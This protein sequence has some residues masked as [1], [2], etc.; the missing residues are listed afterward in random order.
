MNTENKQRIFKTNS[1]EYDLDEI[2]DKMNSREEDYLNWRTER[3][4]KFDADTARQGISQVRT[5]LASGD[6][7]I[8]SGGGFVSA[9]GTQFNPVALD[10]LHRAIGAVKPI[11]EKEKEAFGDKHSLKTKFKNRFYGGNDP[12]DLSMWTDKAKSSQDLVDMLTEYKTDVDT[13]DV[14]YDGSPWKDKTRHMEA[15]DRL[16]NNLNNGTIDAS[17]SADWTALGGDKQF[18][19]KIMGLT[20]PEKSALQKEWEEQEKML[21][22]AGETEENIQSRKKQFFEMK[23][24]E[25]NAGYYNRDYLSRFNNYVGNH[26]LGGEDKDLL[27]LNVLS[28]QIDSSNWTGHKNN[29]GDQVEPWLRR[30]DNSTYADN[31]YKEALKGRFNPELVKDGYNNNEILY[32]YM[33]DQLRLDP[34]QF[35]P[36]DNNENEVY[37]KSTINHEDGTAVKYNTSTNKFTKVHLSQSRYQDLP[38]LL[39]EMS[40]RYRKY[41]ESYSPLVNGG[42]GI[43]AY[44]IPGAKKGGKLNQIKALR[45][46]NKIQYALSGAELARMYEQERLNKYD[47]SVD[48]RAEQQGKTREQI[49]AGDA[50]AKTDTK[51]NTI[52]RNISTGFDVAGAAASF[53]PVI[54]NAAGAILGTIGTVGNLA[55]DAFDDSVSREEMMTNLAINAGLTG[56][57]LVP[58]GGTASLV[59][60]GLKTAKTAVQVGMP[61]YAGYNVL[62]NWDRIKELRKKADEGKL[63]HAERR[64]LNGYYSMASGTVTGVKGNAA[65]AAKHL[66]NNWAGKTAAA[67]ADPFTAI[68]AAKG[69]AKA[70]AVF[71][72]MTRDTKSIK[73]NAKGTPKGKQ[74]TFTDSEGNEFVINKK[75]RTAML[76]AE[77]QAKAAGKT[78]AE[79]DQ[80]IGKAW[81][82]N[83][84]VATSY[85]RE[86]STPR[87]WEADVNNK[88]VQ[89]ALTAP[90]DPSGNIKIGNIE[91]S[92]ES[93][94]I[95]KDTYKNTIDSLK[96]A[97][98]RLQGVS[99]DKLD[100]AKHA[101]GLEAAKQKFAD[102]AEAKEVRIDIDPNAPK[103]GMSDAGTLT[104]GANK[105]HMG[106]SQ[107]NFDDNGTSAIGRYFSSGEGNRFDVHS[108]IGRRNLEL[109]AMQRQ[110]AQAYLNDV[111]GE[112]IGNWAMKHMNTNWEMA[113]NMSGFRSNT[114]DRLDRIAIGKRD[115]KRFLA[116]DAG[117]QQA[118]LREYR[119]FTEEGA[120]VAAKVNRQ[121]GGKATDAQIDDAIKR[122]LNHNSGKVKQAY[123]LAKANGY[124]GT[125][126]DYKASIMQQVRQNYS[127]G[128]STKYH[129]I[130]L[131][132]GDQQLAQF[133]SQFDD[134]AYVTGEARARGL[135]G[136]DVEI[137]RQLA[138]P[139]NKALLDQLK[140]LD[141]DNLAKKQ[142]A[143]QLRNAKRQRVA[144]RNAKFSE[145]SNTPEGKMYI[146]EFKL[147]NGGRKPN[148]SNYAKDRL[149]GKLESYLNSGKTRAELNEFAK[150]PEGARILNGLTT[151]QDKINA[152]KAY[153]QQ[154]SDAVRTRQQDADIATFEALDNNF[155]ITS[156]QVRDANF[157][158]VLNTEINRI[159]TENPSLG[160]QGVTADK[161]KAYFESK[162]TH[163]TTDTFT[164]LRTKLLDSDIDVLMEIL[165]PN[166]SRLGRPVTPTTSVTPT[167]SAV[168]PGSLHS[169]PTPMFGRS[170][171]KL[172]QL[173]DLR[174][175]FTTDTTNKFAQG[176]IIKAQ[177]GASAEQFGDSGGRS[178]GSGFDRQKWEQMQYYGTKA[179]SEALRYYNYIDNQRNNQRILD[180]DKSMKVAV[181]SPNNNTQYTPVTGNFNE[182]QEGVKNTG[183]ILSQMDRMAS[184][185]NNVE[186]GQAGMLEGQLKAQAQETEHNRVDDA[187][188][189]QSMATN[190]A[191]AREVDAQNRAIADKNMGKFVAQ[192]TYVK[193]Q[194]KAMLSN[195][196]TNENTRMVKDIINPLDTANLALKERAKTKA[197]A[198]FKQWTKD[199]ITDTDELRRLYE[200]YENATEEDA[201]DK[202]WE[203]YAAEKKRLWNQW[204]DQYN[205][206]Y[207]RLLSGDYWQN[208]KYGKNFK[209][210]KGGKVDDSRVKRRAEDLKELRKDI[211]HSITTNRKALDNLS[212]ATLLTLKKMLDV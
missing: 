162:L 66:G 49:L 187:A 78:G 149:N 22:E 61:I 39:R 76:A 191:L 165:H 69:N 15:I 54:G 72:D 140:Q 97:D 107:L 197:Y 109:R 132:R 193:N 73:I 104:Q 37:I 67:I 146:E 71:K 50:A 128:A 203:A 163:G 194:T 6:I 155:K 178:N 168:P 175:N 34:E 133:T 148:A 170:G 90:Q 9:S 118:A 115:H 94:K 161:L 68:G 70:S 126:D 18:F 27:S 29:E 159:L 10:L 19:D 45:N 171:G 211:R 147:A 142:Q 153:K 188:V 123:N 63:S 144:E 141:A 110:R 183:Q 179:A 64:E 52:L 44:L 130:A 48:K 122:N 174:Q 134:L 205:D 184:L 154:Y 7:S 74:W 101:I 182:R 53:I 32:L 198:Q 156:G 173:K 169:T 75:Q 12:E 177:N 1:S 3:D 26:W 35:I 43:S 189:K 180:I 143:E 46:G 77:R 16:I 190:T 166:S 84:D 25:L 100:A 65:K 125:L 204:E 160:R 60:K 112:G 181:E 201:K 42:S 192:D 114:D 21:R 98:T 56:L 58:G 30:G 105:W 102:L 62:N 11:P 51:G 40:A 129:D 120:K 199:N 8:G 202:A 106:S 207:D 20:P 124:T 14:N 138:D 81:A 23:L 24:A 121:N 82:E 117:K 158:A 151:E 79:I 57:M 136:T 111:V 113:Q 127:E 150:T 36:I 139:K 33:Q 47:Q 85:S 200:V 86:I 5:A 185:T 89:D 91:F 196:Q 95:L 83:A 103:F 208:W 4:S 31:L 88:A 108:P 116:S 186:A 80:A 210:K 96:P 137:Q 135:S 38:T 13:W 152:M 164:D 99:P 17:D 209:M 41:V 59:G 212:K 92:K 206:R 28:D 167:A 131:Q 176:G 195:N 119:Y 2:L 55:A 172:N 145:F 157:D 87:T 93:A